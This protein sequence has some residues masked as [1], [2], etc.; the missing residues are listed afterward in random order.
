MSLYPI[1]TACPKCGAN[2]GQICQTP[3]ID[4]CDER[5][6]A[7]GVIDVRDLSPPAQAE[8]STLPGEV[9]DT[10]RDA[11]MTSQSNG[12]PEPAER[13]YRL[14]FSFSNMDALH[15][16]HAAMVHAFRKDAQCST[17]VSDASATGGAVTAT[18]DTPPTTPAVESGEEWEGPLTGE[19]QAMIDQA[20]ER[21]KAAGPICDVPPVG[22]QCSRV[23]GHDGPCAASPAPRASDQDVERVALAFA[24]E[25]YGPG[26]DPFHNPEAFDLAQRATVAALAAINGETT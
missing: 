20:W 26:F 24:K 18:A 17:G 23:A 16:A 2:A 5:W 11:F 15:A 22:W 25:F 21:H 9:L 1:S 12:H 14:I 8:A 3:A 6:I 19:E 4:A 10:L 7:S 13:S